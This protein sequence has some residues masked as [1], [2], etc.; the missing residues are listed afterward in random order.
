MPVTN[1]WRLTKQYTL[2]KL[3]GNHNAKLKE[4]DYSYLVRQFEK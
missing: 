3:V 4:A 2:K 1:E